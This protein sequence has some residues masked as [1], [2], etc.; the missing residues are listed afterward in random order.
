MHLTQKK[1]VDFDMIP[2]K[3]ARM[4][5]IVLCKSIS[6]EINN[7]SNG[8]FPNDA[9]IA[10]VSPLDKGISEKKNDMSNFRSVSIFTSSKIYEQVTKKVMD[11]AMSKYLS[12]HFCLST[13]L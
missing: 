6:N 13:K 12:F 2:P 11:A 10:M 5:T 4:A 7:I 1:T 9:K 3:L 8:T